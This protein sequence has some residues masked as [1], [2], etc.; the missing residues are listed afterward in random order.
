MVIIVKLC[1]LILIPNFY[2][3][4][5]VYLLLFKFF[6]PSSH[7]FRCL[8]I[9]FF[10]AF[11]FIYFSLFRVLFSSKTIYFE[12]LFISRIYYLRL[13]IYF[14]YFFTSSFC[15]IFQVFICK[16]SWQIFILSIYFDYFYRVLI[17]R[18]FFEY[19]LF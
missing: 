19:Y 10:F 6:S 12:C 3:V 16:Y 13:F 8:F 4:F 7:L 11:N 15:R 5:V 17:S 1:F 14:E 9:G 2:S 18:I